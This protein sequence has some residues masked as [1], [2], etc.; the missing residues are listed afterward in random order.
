MSAWNFYTRASPR[1]R[2]V[3]GRCENG[4]HQRGGLLVTGTITAKAKPILKWAG[5]KTQ[6]LPEIFERTPHKYVRYHEPFLGS[7]AVFFALAPEQATLADTN[8]NLIGLYL[9]TRDRAT[10]LISE[11]AMLEEEFNT[12][13]D[14]KKSDYYYRCREEFNALAQSSIRQ[15]A[16]MVFLNKTGFNGMYRE[17]RNGMFN[18]PF[19]KRMNINLPK[20]DHIRGCQSLLAKTDILLA[21]FETIVDRAEPGDFVYF[22]PP[23]VP[24]SK[25]SSF[26]AYQAGGFSAD[27]QSRLANVVA[28]LD[29]NQVLVLLSNS[30]TAAVRELFAGLTIDTVFARR[31]INSKGNGRGVVAEVLVRNF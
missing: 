11:L 22:D 8:K 25:S 14:E 18:I 21:G 23:Y 7:G 17:N 5:G 26:T 28:T 3:S 4:G 9:N 27:D 15:S 29:A 30:D 12:Q 6:L 2:C 20:S 13:L 24:L 16:L 31:S 1:E 10:E 19:S